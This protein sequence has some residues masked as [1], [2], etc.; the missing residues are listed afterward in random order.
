MAQWDVY[1]NP[2]PRMREVLPYVVV[3]QS[4]LL[5]GLGTRLVAPLARHL[6]THA[7]M[8]TRL[9]PTV[10]V[11]GE[12]VVL[13]MQECAPVDA[14]TLRKPVASLREQSHLIVGAMDAVISGV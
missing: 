5:G 2:S 13:V 8:T 6:S 7:G 1:P 4:D 3:V 14:R 10:N 11:R 12:P 9:S